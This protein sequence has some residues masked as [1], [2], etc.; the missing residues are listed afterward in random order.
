MFAF[1]RGRLAVAVLGLSAAAVFAQGPPALSYGPLTGC[2]VGNCASANHGTYGPA[3]FAAN[4]PAKK[5]FGLAGPNEPGCVGRSSYPLSDWHYIRQFCG[6]TIQPGT[7]HGYHQTKWR[8]WDESCPAG[9][10][11]CA[12]PA[13][14]T[15]SAPPPFVAPPAPVA[16]PEPSI[17]LD[18]PKADV[19]KVDVPKVEP[20]APPKV[21]PIP[22]SPAPMP[23]S[24]VP[25]P[26]E[27]GKIAIAEPTPLPRPMPGPVLVPPLPETRVVVPPLPK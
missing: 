22:K 15:L 6:P 14:L 26:V 24:A 9:T 1:T 3:L 2:A 13:E 12:P 19:P 21:S 8:R 7:C 4:P 27:P 11:G 10:P 17:P 25:A 23:L 20:I 16:P 5:H 18:M